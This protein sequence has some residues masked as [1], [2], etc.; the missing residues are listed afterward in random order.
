M[1]SLSLRAAAYFP[2]SFFLYFLR[3]LVFLLLTP[4]AD[5]YARV[6]DDYA[7]DVLFAMIRC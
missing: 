6:V 5:I 4:L 2:F 1:P 3:Q 7:A